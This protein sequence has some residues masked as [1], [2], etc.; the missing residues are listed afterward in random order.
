LAQDDPTVLAVRNMERAG[1]HIITDGEI[2]RTS[3]AG[4]AGCS[5]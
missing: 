3:S 1:I 2:R 5:W 4:S